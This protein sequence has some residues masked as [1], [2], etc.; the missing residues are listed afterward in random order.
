MRMRFL[1]T[2][3]VVATLLL[4]ACGSTNRNVYLGSGTDRCLDV[5]SDCRRAHDCCSDWCVNGEC[6]LRP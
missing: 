2:S 5:D 1:R 6:E 3:V 4:I